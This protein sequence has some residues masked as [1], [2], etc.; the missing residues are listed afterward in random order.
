MCV[1]KQKWK[2]LISRMVYCDEFHYCV[3]A[4]L[5]GGGGGGAGGGGGCISLRSNRF[6]EDLACELMTQE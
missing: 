6:V 2:F 5:F 3:L 1:I 4:N